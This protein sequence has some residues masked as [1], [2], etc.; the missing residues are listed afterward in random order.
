MLLSIN[1][2]KD[3]KNDL[4]AVRGPQI[5]NYNIPSFGT[6]EFGTLHGGR[7]DTNGYKFLTVH[8]FGS[9][10]LKVVKGCTV[11][12]DGP[13]GSFT[14]KSDTKDIESFYSGKM[15]KGVT[16]FELFLDKDI[17]AELKK[18]IDKMTLDFGKSGLFKKHE[19][20]FEVDTKKFKKILLEK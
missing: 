13:E 20:T 3:I 11:T 8:L 4:E 6:G 12:F 5:E 16:E 2:I 7:S 17:L 14:V 1:F 10:K 18:P 15:K 19:Y 9:P